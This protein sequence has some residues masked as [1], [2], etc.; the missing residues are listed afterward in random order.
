MIASL[1]KT[2]LENLVDNDLTG[3]LEGFSIT[4]NICLISNV[5]SCTGSAFQGY[6][7]LLTLRKPSILSN[8]HLWRKVSAIQFVFSALLLC[9]G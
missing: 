9:G 3:F 4:E 5:I 2:A 7:S 6:A 8:G 1:L